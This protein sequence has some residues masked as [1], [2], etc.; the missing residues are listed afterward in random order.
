M[1]QFVEQVGLETLPWPGN[2][3]D[4]NPIENCWAHLKRKIAQKRPKTKAEFKLAIDQSWKNDI[5]TDYCRNLIK[6][7]P[8]RIRAV[9]KARG[10]PTKY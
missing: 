8:D 10:G 6:S 2:S 1:K 7:M 4:L 5:T 9:M 3:P